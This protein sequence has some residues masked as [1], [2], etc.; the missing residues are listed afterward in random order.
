MASFVVAW[1]DA[2]PHISALCQDLCSVSCFVLSFPVLFWK[3]TNFPL[4][5]QVTCPSSRVKC[6]IVFPDSQSVSTCSP[7]S[8]VC[9]NSLRLLLSSASMLRPVPT[10]M[11]SVLNHSHSLASSL[12]SS[13]FVLCSL[14]S[15]V[16]PL[17]ASFKLI[18]NGSLC[19]GLLRKRPC[20]NPPH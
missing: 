11:P 5:F 16:P 17:K 15:F 1:I 19:L 2:F 12:Q 7:W 6:L 10:F 4:S 13:D 8:L 20:L 9:S 3:I 14:R 18:V